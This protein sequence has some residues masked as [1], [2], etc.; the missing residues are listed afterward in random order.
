V[1]LAGDIGGTNARLA[2]FDVDGEGMKLVDETSY[3]SGEFAG[4]EQIV[5]KFM[6]AHPGVIQAA[7]FGVAGPVKDGVVHTPNLPWIVRA[8][9]LAEELR[10]ASVWLINDLEA[11][12]H[13][14]TVLGAAETICINGGSPDPTGN[15]AVISAGTGL[16]QAGMCWDGEQHRVFASEGGHCDFAATNDIETELLRYLLQHFE[17]VSYERVLSGPGLVNIYNFFRDTGHGEEPTW[18]KEEMRTSNPA[19]VISRN[20]LTGKSSLCEQAL[21]LFVSIYGAQTGNLAL[22]LLATGGVYLGGGI[23]PK[24]APKLTSP[25]FMKAF[26]A[27]GR[28]RPLMESFPVCIVTNEKTALLGAAKVAASSKVR[29]H[30]NRA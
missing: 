14:T 6:Q 8:A 19:A 22:S 10:L 9:N 12:A 23:A 11:N 3:A 21:D 28:M 29:V 26:T 30:A 24:I 25:L 7:C 2:L 15:R 27:K 16:G 18:L 20:A 13:G 5:A 4:L 1:I 17:H